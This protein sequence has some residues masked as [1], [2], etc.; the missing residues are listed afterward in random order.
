[1]L[2]KTS[3]TYEQ[4][5]K[6]MTFAGGTTDDP[7]DSGGANATSTLFTVTGTV[8][9]KLVAV[10]TT[11]L[12]GASA[13]IA[14]GTAIT[15][16]GLIAQTTATDIDAGEIWHDATPDAS[17]EATTVAPERIVNQDIKQ[18]VATADITSGV[19]KYICLWR[20]ITPN[21]SVAA[22]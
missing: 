13:T 1:M 9:M 20:P 5:I 15:A 18:V 16:G 22:A 7:G 17:I 12:A 11:S 14:V 19:I 2:G 6:T 3:E 21:A 8:F 10:C 4:A